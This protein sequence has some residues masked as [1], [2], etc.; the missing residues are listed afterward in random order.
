MRTSLKRMLWLA[1][2]ALLAAMTPGIAAAQDA[3]DPPAIQREFR[4]AWVSTVANIDWP[5]KPGLS[6]EQQQKEAL[7]IL[8]KA[9]EL[10][11]NALIF[12]VRP[13]ADAMYKSSLEPWSEFLTGE[14]GK[15]PEP[16]YDPLEFWVTEAHKRGIELH[17]WFNPYRANHPAAKTMSNDSVVK[18]HPNWVRKLGDKG[19][20]WMDPAEPGVQKLSLDVVLDVVKRYDV[21][22]VHF[23][24]YFYPYDSYNDGK[25]FPDDDLWAAYQKTGG[26]MTRSEWRRDAVNKFVK[27]IHD[28]VHATRNDVLFGMSPFGIWR[29]NNPIGV[30]GLDQYE[31]LYADAKLW[32]N[33]GWVDYWTPQLYW[34]I[35]GDQSYTAL[36]G[37]WCQENKTHKVH[38]WPGM[39]TYRAETKPGAKW[40]PQELRDQIAVTRK[41]YPAASGNV[42]FTFNTLSGNKAGTGDIVKELY[43][44]PALIP[45]STWLDDKAP[46][47]PSVDVAKASQNGANAV[48]VSIKP[49]GKE[50]A[51]LY[52]VQAQDEAGAWKTLIV[53]G[54][55]GS[56][57]IPG[58]IGK[59]AVSAVDDLGNASDKEVKKISK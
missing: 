55:Q 10:N 15:A 9:K 48:T 14:Q 8:D 43:A 45:A 52:T 59:V 25:D 29:P 22:G 40:T 38:I 57:T 12:Q 11:L 20:Y 16:F 34:P 28:G 5:S 39:G 42:H 23:D 30:K 37:W 41:M 47:K 53:P 26:K 36:L 49:T 21:D 2:F 18:K 44:Q 6:T 27:S 58:N 4:A 33:E 24:D 17:A 54:D 51:F 31:A 1:A 46:G 35:K 32:L 13:M 7:A 19:Y 3:N 50:R 56:V